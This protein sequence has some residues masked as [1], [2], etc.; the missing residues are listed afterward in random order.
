CRPALSHHG[1]GWPARAALAARDLL[2]SGVGGTVWQGVSA[3]P[4]GVARPRRAP[5][6]TTPATK[7]LVSGRGT[8]GSDGSP[9]WLRCPFSARRGAQGAR[10]GRGAL[11]EP[12]SAARPG[13]SR[14]RWPARQRRDAP[15]D[16]D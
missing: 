16:L 4:A 3:G 1:P 12:S 15:F 11:G 13:L 8:P 5:P 2:G 7:A 10:E 6:L 9:R 14:T